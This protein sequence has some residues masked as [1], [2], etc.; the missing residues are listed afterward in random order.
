M[1]LAGMQPLVMIQNTGLFESGDALRNVILPQLIQSKSALGFKRLRLW[2]A[3][4]STGE[5][6]Y[7]LAMFLLEESAKLL[8]GWTFDILA[9]D[10]NDNSLSAAKAGVYGD[11][12]LRSTSE[13]LKQKYFKPFDQKHL[14]VS[15]QLKSVIDG[16]LARRG[17]V[18]LVEG[19]AGIGKTRLAEEL[20]ASAGDVQVGW[21]AALDDAGMPPLWPWAR[22][23]R[24][25]R[26]L[27]YCWR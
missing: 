1:H 4:C 18:A 27:A 12:A 8:S 19:S 14:Q 23:V 6:P 3:G 5:E 10:L 2:S 15:D 16:A 7:T 11:Y 26:R 22:A 9:T 20:A 25:I 21:G 24:P 17:S 13:L